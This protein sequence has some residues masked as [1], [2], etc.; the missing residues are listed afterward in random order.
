MRRSNASVRS[1]R[2]RA[3]IKMRVGLHRRV[4]ER[5]LARV[6]EAFAAW[7]EEQSK[8]ADAFRRLFIEVLQEVLAQKV[9]KPVIRSIVAAYQCQPLMGGATT[10]APFSRSRWWDLPSWHLRG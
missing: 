8:L 4:F 9:V 1:Q 2:R 5:Q 3:Q 6:S 7:A 10:R